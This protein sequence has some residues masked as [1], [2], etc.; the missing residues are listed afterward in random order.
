MDYNNIYTNLINCASQRQTQKECYY[1]KHHII[2]RC[3]GGEDI[4]EN[5]VCLTAREH[6]I[7][8]QLLVK[9]HPNHTGLTHAAMMMT[10]S[11]TTMNGR[12]SSK[13]RLYGWLRT[14]YS[15][16]M[17]IKQQGKGNNNYGTVWVFSRELQASKKIKIDQLNLFL[18]KGWE[19]GRVI[20]FTKTQISCKHCQVK[21]EAICDTTQV[22][23]H[24]KY[25]SDQC[26]VSYRENINV[27]ENTIKDNITLIKQLHSNG[28]SLNAICKK[29]GWVGA[30]G[31]Y[32]TLIKSAV[33]L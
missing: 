16:Q 7:A 21:F 22:R 32:Y 13:N 24:S 31:R 27:I 28:V 19:K 20:N 8:H 26:R 12:R 5:I 17:S 30:Q 18:L 2:P 9:M 33:A 4:K 25:C 1:E 11:N 3:L 15:K 23:T 6:Y 29:L 14:K 10:V